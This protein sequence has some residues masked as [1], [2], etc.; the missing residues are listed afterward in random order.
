MKKNN[1]K[2]ISVICTV[3][4]VTL[5]VYLFHDVFKVNFKKYETQ[6][7]TQITE[8]EKIETKAFVVR[9]EQYIDSNYTGTVVPLVTDGMRVARGDSVARICNSEQ[10]ASEYA[11][12]I[13]SKAALERY[14]MLSTQSDLNSLDMEKLNAEIDERY[15]E[16]LN[17]VNSGNYSQV[18]EKIVDVEDKI[19]SKQILSDGSVDLSEKIKQLQTEINVIEAKN[20]QVSDLNAPASGYYISEIDGYE[21][22]VDYTKADKL[23]V[24]QV[25]KLFETKPV[26]VSGK[27]G[28]IVTSYEWYLCTVIDAKNFGLVQKDNTLKIN[29]PY[30]G[31]KDVRVKVE[32]VSEEKDGKIAVVFSCNLMNESYANMRNLDI[33]IVLNEY[34]GYKVDS[35]AIRQTKDSK[36]NSVDTVFILRGNIMNTR[37][38]DIL[39]DA[40][41][42]VI[43]KIDKNNEQEFKPVALYDE[44]IVKGRDLKDGKLVN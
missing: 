23:D 9:D 1:S 26:T 4:A 31:C 21:N 8:Q 33:E 22:A 34:T 40:G 25:E 43:A 44:V 19:V 28:K 37:K 30:Y 11:A 27:M 36:G 20:I 14:Q 3:V 35:A 38:I 12:L 24:S 29:I 32:S 17:I 39:Y 13:K 15:K 18:E 6:M 10:D 16:L 41:D 5:V 7:V 2:W 42:Y